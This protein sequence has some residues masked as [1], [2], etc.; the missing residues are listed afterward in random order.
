VDRGPRGYLFKM[1]TRVAISSTGPSLALGAVFALGCTW[2]AGNS[3]HLVASEE[4]PDG[5]SSGGAGGASSGANAT[6]PGD[7]TDSGANGAGDASGNQSG[8]GDAAVASGDGSVVTGAGGCHALVVQAGA[9]V[10][11]T[12]AD[13]F[14]WY[15][16]RCLPRT[17]SLL[18]N[19]AADA[20]GEHGGYLRALSYQAAGKTRAIKG[21]GANGWQGFGY[22]VSHFGSSGDDADT[23]SVG[24]TYRT[25]LAGRH[26]AIHEFKW[27]ISPGGLVHVTVHWMFSTGR[28]HPLFAITLDSSATKAG[29]VQA[30]S[31]SPY[32]DLS[33]D[34]GAQGD[35]SGDGWGDTHKFTTTGSG[36]VSPTSAW[37]YTKANTIPYAYEWSTPTDAEMG[38]VSTLSW[39]SRISGGDYGGGVLSGE[40]GKTGTKLLTDIPDWEWPYQLNQYELPYA[41]SS[42]RIAWGAT[43][44]AVGSASYTAFGQTLSGYPDQSYTVYV[45]LG[46]HATSAVAA[47]VAAVEATQGVSL[48]AT[49]GTVAT[50]GIGGPGRTDM[51]KFPQAGFDPV[52]AAWTVDAAAN[53]ATVSFKAGA[54]MIANPMFEVRGYTAT[55]APAS[56]SYAGRALVADVDYF[57]TVDTA[58]QRLW[59]TLNQTVTGTGTL[60]ID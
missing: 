19:D 58:G 32:G 57:A 53:A 52:Y 28:A 12:S 34:N 39:A 7:D 24:G 33:W 11:G 50:Q 1:R 36:P 13:T 43:F 56:V 35:I 27:D 10:E 14:T 44:G 59:L 60:V 3:S 18:R 31:R 8:P 4:R 16:D 49:R 6:M 21:S 2:C 41:T 15:D 45:V 51:V 48:T 47:Q 46:T 40:W 30:D 42:H 9:K 38:L 23:M 29:T 25:V 20:F 26:H 5:A 54:S 37:D 55:A 17:A 22:I